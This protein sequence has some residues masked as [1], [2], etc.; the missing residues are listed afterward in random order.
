MTLTYG[1]KNFSAQSLSNLLW[2]IAKI[3][4]KDMILASSVREEVVARGLENFKS[5]EV[6]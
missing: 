2:A 4:Y 1:L 3:Q 5:Q 6:Y